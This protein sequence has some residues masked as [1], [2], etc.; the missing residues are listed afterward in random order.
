MAIRLIEPAVPNE[1]R[2]LTGPEGTTFYDD[3]L[4]YKEI[5]G[6]DGVEVDLEATSGSVENVRTVV[7]A[8]V[9]TAALVWGIPGAP[10][11]SEKV[12][13]GAE[14][15]GAMYPQPVWVFTRKG[16]NIDRV[17]D[18]DGMQIY[19]GEKGS[20]SRLLALFILRQEGIGD[21]IEFVQ[22]QPMTVAQVQEAVQSNQVAAIIAVGEPDSE[23][24]DNLLRSP[25][26]E[27]MSIS[28]ADGFAFHYS[29]LRAIRFPEGGHDIAANIPDH[30]LQLLAARAQL[31]VSDPFPPS[32][33]DLL[34]QAAT[35]IHGGATPFSARGEFPKPE[36]A[37][38]TLN[39]AAENFYTNGLPKL[40]RY[41]PFRLATWIN[42]F[43]TA[44]VAIGSVG[45][46]LVKILPVLISLPFRRNIR[47]GYDDLRAI[48][49]S[50]ATGTDDKTLLAELAKVDQ[51]TANISIPMRKLEIQWLELRQYLHDMRDRLEAS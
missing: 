45:L 42:R 47:R 31:I 2:M 24:I 41:V 19:A 21:D 25:E 12:E 23:L 9:P 32:L 7:E 43:F 48:E 44:A 20:D 1:I 10:G 36:T 15:L 38:F 46:T 29:A 17:R 11:Q 37:P 26:L 6:R 35:E 50:A 30:D 13:K 22:D 34:L 18:L 8:D 28:R 5:L 3:G 49:V 40:Q 39:R 27:V 51:A 16:V 4:R 14:S 33:A